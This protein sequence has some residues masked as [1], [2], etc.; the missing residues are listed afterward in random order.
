MTG[1]VRA[2]LAATVLICTFATPA[3][4]AAPHSGSTHHGSQHRGTTVYTLDDSTQGNP[5][6]VASHGRWFYVGATATGAIYRGRLGDPTVHTFIPGV[7]GRAAVGM[8]VARHSLYVA[9]GPTGKVF[10]YDLRSPSAPPRT[11]DT[12][13]GGFLND[14]VVTGRGDVYV[15]DSF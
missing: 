6:G 15:T 12:G 4:G 13:T 9:G 8:K 11:F 14:L 7:A 5:E 2:A 1:R 10:V 3:A